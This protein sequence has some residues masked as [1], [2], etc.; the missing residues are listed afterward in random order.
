M[1]DVE[2]WIDLEG[3]EPPWVR[4]LL[5]TVRDAPA[6][7]PAEDARMKRA[8]HRALDEHERT[9]ARRRRWAWAAAGSVVVTGAA[10]ACFLA[11]WPAHAP[12]PPVAG[13][14]AHAALAAPAVSA[15]ATA[16]VPPAAPRRRPMRPPQPR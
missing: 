9:H 3:P 1:N 14:E 7:S 11:L 2:R 12:H 16:T 8:L 4:E 10:A 15:P 5:D 6:L 13:E